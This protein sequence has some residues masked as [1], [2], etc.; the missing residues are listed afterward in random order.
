M[1]KW[2]ITEYNILVSFETVSEFLNVCHPPCVD[3]LVRPMCLKESRVPR[4]WMIEDLNGLIVTKFCP[5]LA[6]HLMM[7]LS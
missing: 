6:E 1:F 7:Q 4:P 5:R 2:T 3:C